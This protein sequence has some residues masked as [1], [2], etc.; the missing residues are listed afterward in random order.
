MERA[1][2]TR[3]VLQSIWRVG[4]NAPELSEDVRTRL[5]AYIPRYAQTLGLN[6]YA[7]GG[8]GDHL[9]I[10]H[11]LVPDKPLTTALEEV[12][13]AT[14]R[15]LRETFKLNTFAWAPE[16]CLL[17]V[18]P[19]DLDDLSVYVRENAARHAAGRP[20]PEWEG[21]EESTEEPDTADALPDWLQDAAARSRQNR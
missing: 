14:V 19:S 9:H 20:L 4:E 13:R 2:G 6:V 11:D 8:V 5:A 3:I 17:S 7:V 18:R 16:T 12:R 1:G 21:A 15:F 10:V